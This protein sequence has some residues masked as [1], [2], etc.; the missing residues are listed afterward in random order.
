M[1]ELTVVRCC[2]P[3]LA[4]LKTGSLFTCPCEGREALLADVRRLN[5][6]L[7]PCGLRV[8][9][10]RFARD[11]A[12]VYVFRPAQLRRD[13]N[14]RSARAILAE[15]GYGDADCGGCLRRLIER[16]RS[17]GEFPHEIGLFLGFPPE[18]V[19]GFIDNRAQNCKL[20]G[21]WKVYGD[22]DRARRIFAQYKKCT[23][24]YCR[25][26]RAGAA[27]DQLAVAT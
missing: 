24:C 1:S 25:A 3:T 23:Q 5:G 16:L 4:G 26:L 9:P 17:G 13:L 21:D 11:R 27:L 18:D 22:A 2:A 6:T 12:L 19:R 14:V 8:L 7:L 15:A 20:V 10:L